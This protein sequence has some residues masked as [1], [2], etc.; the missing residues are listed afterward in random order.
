VRHQ[1]PFAVPVAP[2]GT[3][4]EETFTILEYLRLTGRP[5]EASNEIHTPSLQPVHWVVVVSMGVPRR[6]QM[7]YMHQVC[8]LHTKARGDWEPPLGHAWVN[9]CP[10]EPSNERHAPSPQPAHKN[11]RGL[12]PT[13]GSRLVQ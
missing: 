3:Q 7:R 11:K 1:Q 9:R 13:V 10:Q 4:V 6:P 5:G 2:S 8:S 12:E